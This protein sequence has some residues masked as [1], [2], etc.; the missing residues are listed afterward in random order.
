MLASKP[1]SSVAS[2]HAS[3]TG[4]QRTGGSR[5]LWEIVAVGAVLR[6]IALGHKSFWLDEIASVVVARTPSSWFWPWLWHEEGNMTLYYVLLRPWLHLGLSE[7]TVRLL[8]VIPGVASIPLIYVLGA[9][10][11]GKSAGTLSALFLAIHTCAVVYSQEARSYSFLVLGTIA[12]TFLFVRLIEAPTFSRAFTYSLVAGATLYCH[13][14]GM[15][16]IF[17]HLL[18]VAFLPKRQQPWKQLAFTLVLLAIVA[19]PV[20]WMIHLQDPGHINWV[21]PP[22]WLELY[23]LGAFLAAE[24]GKGVGSVL[25]A[26]DL[27][28]LG[29][30]FV[31]LKQVWSMRDIG[32]QRWRYGLVVSC[33]LTPVVISLLV[34]VAKPIFFHRFLIIC[35]PAWVLMTAVG[36]EQIRSHRWRTAA[37]AGVCLL[38]VISTAISY[39]RVREDWRGVATYLIA[40]GKPQDRVLYY[41]PIAYFAAENYRDWLP[42]GN[43][44]RPAG[45]K[46]VPPSQDWQKR[47]EDAQRIWLVTYPA[48]LHDQ[49]QAEIEAELQK[50]MAVVSQ[51]SFRAV[52]VTEYRTR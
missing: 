21:Q 33:L 42:E 26:L 3:T 37:I 44:A 31:R 41:E 5:L 36:V 28:L 35:L 24:S 4:M 52:T 38:S 14:F 12:A 20:A 7:T 10:L 18:S 25:L 15:L 6:L 29:F 8:S 51:K 34:S 47:I 9:R 50:R 22:S 1:D 49:T 48:K 19:V 16:V 40:Q 46:V 2:D 23:H 32:L 45:V 13:Y 39:T 27:V 17:S 43:I 30:F 11:F